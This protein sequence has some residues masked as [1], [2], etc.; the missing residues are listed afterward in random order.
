MPYRRAL[1]F[2]FFALCLGFAG[3]A[4][5]D[6]EAFYTV[7]FQG[8]AAGSLATHE[9][10]GGEVHTDFHY[11]DNGRG[12][13]IKEHWREDG[14]GVPVAYDSNGTSTFGGLIADS[15][16]A[17]GSRRRW[18]SVAD[19]GEASLDGPAAY[20]PVEGSPEINARLVA[21]ALRH[22]A[23][24]AM[25][26]AGQ[27]RVEK[28]LERGVGNAA[29]GRTVTLYGVS[30]VD[31]EPAYFWLGPAPGYRLFALIVPGWMNCISAGFEA[32]V[33]AL[34]AAQIEA[35]GE[36]LQLLAGR[37][38]HHFA[39][40]ILIRN[41][42]VFD[43][44]RAV[45]GPAQDVYVRGGLIAAL[46]PAGSQPE[47]AGTV[48]DASGKTLLPGLFDMHDH[49][50]AWNAVQQLAGGVTSARDMGNENAVLRSLIER[51]DS[52]RA[53][54]ARITAAGFIEGESPYSSNG[55]ILVSNPVEVRRAI[56]WYAQRGYP[57]IK[58]YNSFAPGWVAEAATY[59]HQRGLRVS[60]HIPSFMRA[61]E[62]VR[63]GY[64]EIQHVN[65]LLL[66]FYATPT[67]DTRTLARFTLI[68]DN[69]YALDLDSAQVQA[70][71]ALLAQ[72]QT[73]IDPTLTAFESQF[74]QAQG[75]MNP[76]FAAIAAR[77]PPAYQRANLTNSADLSPA[78]APRSR[79]SFAKMVDFIGRCYRAGIPIVAGTD[80]PAGWT[81]HR[82]LE[83]YVRA[84]IP[85]AEVLRIA[86]WNGAKYT[87]TLERTGSITQ[88]K[89]ADLILVDGNPT[90]DIAAIRRIALAMKQG[91]V[92]FPAEIQAA[93][94]IRPLVPA[95][96]PVAPP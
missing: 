68:K 94:G 30:G 51:I 44:E 76:S 16:L 79:A 8:R 78:D 33:P 91:T 11:R 27:M 65:Q 1:L 15:Y 49:E 59:A 92:Y 56:D 4:R 46:Y 19:E 63:A 18:K 66:N 45:L 13:D 12:P 77:Y 89:Q 41:A 37:L 82:E 64:D 61:E 96:Q 73:V 95:L 7:L 20:L 40:P 53:L 69:A 54:G 71:I 10:A 28:L 62:A 84:G 3:L 25:L 57:Q 70:F 39:E 85:A 31:I 35:A 32:D 22:G 38:A 83:L 72:H 5:A 23:S 52:G 75:E 74:T 60:G 55:G 67:T 48:F 58:I 80:G 43:A 47:A 14:Q 88:G 29:T 34:Q 36:Q 2:N 81:L 87:R 24:L 26:P 21:A 86:T 6:S 50:T 9:T 93:T 42:R 17:Q 90:Q